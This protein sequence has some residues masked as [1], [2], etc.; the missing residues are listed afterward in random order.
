MVN[1]LLTEMDGF[2]KEELVFVVGTTNLMESLDPALLRPGRFEFHLHIPFPVAEDRRAI[3]SLYEKKLGLT[4]SARA[5]DYAV[6]RTGDVVEGQATRYSGDHLQALCRSL[7]RNQIRE[8]RLG[9]VDV[10]DVERA[11]SSWVDR[12]QLS[13]KE[14]VVVA[15]HEA[16][17]AIVALLCPN[18]PPIERISIRGDLPGSLGF[19]SY[20]DSAHRY[21]V[22]QGQLLDHLCTLYG[23]REAE[24]L[25]L[26]ELSAGSA[27]DLEQAADIAHAL[28]ERLGMGGRDVGARHLEVDDAASFSEE[29]KVSVSNAVGRILEE[30][31]QRA[32]VFL[33]TQRELLTTLRDLLVDKKV[34]DREAL[35]AV[36]PAELRPR[37]N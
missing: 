18:T 16:G 24:L 37:S 21:V 31:R 33:E 7:A 23:G 19:V 4:W 1:Q 35:A 36:W 22:S 27:A 34:L 12:P 26:G 11:L 14:E 20:A 13:P 28:V 15:T 8:G 10:P 32:R 25:L 9:P 17:H 2:R 6:K 29:L 5:L 30:Q 3:L